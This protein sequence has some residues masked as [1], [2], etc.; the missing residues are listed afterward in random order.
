VLVRAEYERLTVI[1]MMIFFENRW[2]ALSARTQKRDG[3]NAV[4]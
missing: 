3:I 2:S 1:Q 4:L